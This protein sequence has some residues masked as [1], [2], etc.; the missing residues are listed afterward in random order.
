MLRILS[1]VVLCCLCWAQDADTGAFFGLDSNGRLLFE[2]GNAS[3][4]LSALLAQLSSLRAAQTALE[5][6]VCLPG[7][8]ALYQNVSTVG[9]RNWEFF[10]INGQSFLAAAFY[11]QNDPPRGIYTYNLNSPILRF[12]ATSNSFV[13][14]QL[15]PT[16][17]AWSV[18]AFTMGGQTFLAYANHYDGGG[19]TLNSPI[20]R[21]NGSSFVL[22]QT[23]PT[24][25]A[26][27]WEFFTV[28]NQSFLAV[29]NLANWQQPP[30]VYALNSQILRFNTATN[31]FLHFQFI[32]TQGAMDFESFVIGNESFLAVS[33]HRN[34]PDYTLNS[35]VFRFDSVS[36]T[37]IL[38]QSIPTQA[39]N[40]FEF[41]TISGA[42]YLAVANA[43]DDTAAP[44]NSQILRF[45][46]T[47]NIFTPFQSIPTVGATD[48]EFFVLGG[49]SY[50]VCAMDFSLQI[51]RFDAANGGRFVPFQTVA[52]QGQAYVEFF[53]MANQSFLAT[54]AYIRQPPANS[55][56]FRLRAPCFE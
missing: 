33:N 46:T 3:V 51:F 24:V 49:Q 56:I 20:Y 47:S 17:G 44:V 36:N 25:G 4:T 16:V 43:Y 10:T 26:A 40:D 23:I 11:E 34:G 19:S 37:F 53:T 35:Q 31:S 22:F 12:D 18:K 48:W 15:I 38:F 45:N 50:L 32:S 42:S 55:P 2:D 8:I 27:T 7:R 9:C 39:S 29:A 1:L 41:F 54:A 14:F 30:F 5:A 6:E 28:N 52:T 13:P 21:F